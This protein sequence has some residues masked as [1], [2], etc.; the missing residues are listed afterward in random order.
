M[1]RPIFVQ[2]MDAYDSGSLAGPQTIEAIAETVGERMTGGMG[3]S[4]YLLGFTKKQF[5]ANGKALYHPPRRSQGRKIQWPERHV[6]LRRIMLRGDNYRVGSGAL[7]QFGEEVVKATLDDLPSNDTGEQTIHVL[8]SKKNREMKRLIAK[9][10][11]EVITLA[12]LAEILRESPNLPK[13]ALLNRARGL[14]RAATRKGNW[15]DHRRQF[16]K[17][18][19]NAST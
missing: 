6:L 4:L 14:V 17:E 9:A 5:D 15:E 3:K 19:G 8:A 13:V 12:E 7:S 16:E 2:I 1:Q 11:E 10:S 18:H